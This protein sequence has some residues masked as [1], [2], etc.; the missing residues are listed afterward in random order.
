MKRNLLNASVTHKKIF[1]NRSVLNTYAIF[2]GHIPVQRDPTGGSQTLLP[3]EELRNRKDFCQ[4]AGQASSSHS[5]YKIY[6]LRTCFPISGLRPSWVTTEEPS[7]FSCH[8]RDFCCSCTHPR[9]SSPFG[10]GW[11]RIPSCSCIFV[12][13]TVI[14][15]GCLAIRGRG[16]EID[17]S[18]CLW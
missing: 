9:S 7:I 8:S 4:F 3:R 5:Q 15:G 12:L 18:K 17:V 2:N 10:Q 11:L 14:L 16:S 1:L 6:F 13:E